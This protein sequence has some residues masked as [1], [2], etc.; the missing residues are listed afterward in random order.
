M[1]ERAWLVRLTA[2]ALIWVGG[3]EWLFGRVISRMAASPALEGA[4]RIAI[5]VIGRSGLFLISTAFLVAFTLYLGEVLQFGGTA[6]RRRDTA[7]LSLAIYLALFGVLLAAHAA[8]TA[9][10]GLREAAWL[11]ITFNV[12]SLVALGWA[13]ARGVLR[14]ELPV[15]ARAGIGVTA[16][17]YATWFYSVLVA[18]LMGGAGASLPGTGGA[19]LL[20]EAA[21]LLAPAFFFAATSVPAGRWRRPRSWIVPGV[22]LALF[23]AGNIADILVDQGFTGV[24]TIWSVG[25]TLYLPWPLY[26]LSLT[27]FLH[28]LGTCFAK[29]QNRAGSRYAN[30]N[31]GLGLLLLLYA[32]FYLQL[33]YQHLL[34]LLA[35]LLLSRVARP[36][37]VV[38]GTDEAPQPGHVQP[39]AAAEQAQSPPATT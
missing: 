33:T 32:G 8:L 19:L 17:A 37:D 36:F 11:D 23:S 35:V 13:T 9:F 26:A 4:G 24:F 34:A 5:E 31:T 22:V 7:G 12:L 39:A 10:A 30:P 18:E 20:G 2:V 3:I 1:S 21:A 29:E 27:L 28:A 38:E 16:L 25:F 15:A 6:N 14:P